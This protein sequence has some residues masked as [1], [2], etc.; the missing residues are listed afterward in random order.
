M[1]NSH[2]KVI[3]GVIKANFK[4][5]V[6]VGIGKK[7]LSDH[8]FNKLFIGSKEAAL[9]EVCSILYQIEK[10]YSTFNDCLRFVPNQYLFS[11]TVLFTEN[12]R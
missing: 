3:S 9:D 12:G 1:A 2:N 6:L 4:N 10:I 5:R 7:Y 8:A 11:S